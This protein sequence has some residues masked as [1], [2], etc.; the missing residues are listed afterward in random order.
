MR[1]NGRLCGLLRNQVAAASSILEVVLA[2][3]VLIGLLIST[4]PI[5]QEMFNLVSTGA[6]RRSRLFWATPSTLS[7][8]IEFIKMLAKH[9][10][11][12]ALEV[13]LY[14]I[15]R[16]M[17]LGHESAL[18]KLHQRCFHR[19]DLPDPA[20]CLCAVLRFHHGRMASPPLIPNP[21]PMKGRNLCLK[22]LPGYRT[23]FACALRPA[24][25]AARFLLCRG[26]GYAAKIN[27]RSTPLLSGV[28]LGV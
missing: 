10:P 26:Y 12:S 20:V 22:A 28:Y 21:T 1:G 4:V 25:G 17:I 27:K 6:P 8:G 23:I 14:A 7:I 11:G 3:L 16:Q 19:A 18:E 5:A 24:R 13:L 15:A 9:S 2:I